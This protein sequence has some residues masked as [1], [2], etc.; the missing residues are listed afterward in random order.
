MRSIVSI[1]LFACI[2]IAHGAFATSPSTIIAG[3]HAGAWYPAAAAE[4]ATAIMGYEATAHTCFDASIAP[5]TI[6]AIIVPH[7]GFIYSGTIAAAAYRLVRGA[8]IDRIIILAPSHHEPLIG[9]AIPK[10][11]AYQIPSATIPIDTDALHALA[12]TSKTL[13]SEREP[14]LFEAEHAIEMQLPFVHA[15][16]PGVKIVPVLVGLLDGAAPKKIAQNIATLITPHTLVIVST[17]LTHFGTQY[18]YTPFRDHVLQRI[19]R[20]D[21]ELLEALQAH[22]LVALNR[23]QKKQ[24]LHACGA[25]PLLILA[26]LIA[27]NALGPVT[28]QLIAYGTSHQASA[29]AQEE[30]KQCVSYAALVSATAQNSPQKLS[31]YEKQALLA[32]ARACIAQTLNPSVDDEQLLK[33]IA[34]PTLLQNS[35][36]FVTLY[37]IQKGKRTLRGCIG[38]ITPKEPLFE[39]IATVARDAAF[40]DSRFSPL[41]KQELE[42]V[43]IEI[44]ILTPPRAVKSYHDIILNTHG[45]ILTRGAASAV[46]LPHVPAEFGWT[47]ETTLEQLSQKAGLARNAWRFAETQFQ[48]FEAQAFSES[49]ACSKL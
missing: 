47:L 29:K 3:S 4:I 49:K 35:G 26:Q 17:D 25:M 13:A 44:S 14:T 31:S 41:T 37:Q 30:P 40:H 8:P 32:Y 11:T 20:S 2:S 33:P 45:I 48:V 23:L 6:R 16:L 34:T 21:A 22:D 1:T 18:G 27:Q 24:E 46:F 12:Q 38:R 7:A 5:E 19:Q 42:S 43:R 10:A 28:T 9:I 36:A 39:T 15:T